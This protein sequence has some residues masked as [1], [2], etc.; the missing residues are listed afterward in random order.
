MAVESSSVD[1]IELVDIP[2]KVVLI[3]PEDGAIQSQFSLGL[4][5][6]A[7]ALV[8]AGVE[9][10]TLCCDVYRPEDIELVRMFSRSGARVFAIGGQYPSFREVIRMCR[11]IRLAARRAVIILGGH[12]VSPTPEF[13]LERTGADIGCIGEADR[14]VVDVVTALCGG[15]W[16]NNV[17]G[18]AIQCDGIVHRTPPPKEIVALGRGP[19]SWPAWDRFPVESYVT[20]PR[21]Y[22]FS[23]EDRV[24]SVVTARGCPYSCNFCY[25]PTR[26]REYELTDVLDHMEYLISRYRLS[27]FYI[28]DDLLMVNKHRVLEFC[29]GLI[30]RQLRVR[31]TVAGRFDTV[32]R[33]VLEALREA[34]CISVFYGAESGDQAV[35]DRM[36]KAITVEQIY[37]GVR[38]TRQT[39]IFCRVGA[40]FGQPGETEASLGRTLTMLKNIAY[41]HYEE[42][43]IYG[44]VPFPGTDLY[45]WCLERGLLK[46]HEDFFRRFRFQPR[47]LDQM[48]VNMTAVRGKDPKD[49]LD[50][51]NRELQLFYASRR[52]Y[53]VRALKLS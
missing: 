24:L 11:L 42:R 53:W 4:G 3:R 46:N 30:G 8:N 17:P 9:V 49:L 33:E 12:L 50:A 38:L 16:P 2:A 47:A 51:A 41:G 48:P 27:G 10:A 5:Y 22:P 45:S 23:A 13:V 40:M 31:F 32:D 20:G 36:G 37:E 28:E 18:V 21:Y 29:R 19:T 14:S 35:L 25:H 1:S 52:E 44:C 39:G 7:R 6:V 26:Y 34:G 43:F 15:Q